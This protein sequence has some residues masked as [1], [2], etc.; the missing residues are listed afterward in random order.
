MKVSIAMFRGKDI[1][2]EFPASAPA[3]SLERDPKYVR[4]SEWVEEG[5]S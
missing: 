3:S 2:H 5:R 1:G 4:I